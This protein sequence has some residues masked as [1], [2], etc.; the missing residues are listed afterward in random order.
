MLSDTADH[1][2]AMLCHAALKPV[3]D[4]LRSD[5]T[6]VLLSA[7]KTVYCFTYKLECFIVLFVHA[8]GNYF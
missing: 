2:Q 3:A 7:M 6:T 8:V 1:R 5:D 4:L